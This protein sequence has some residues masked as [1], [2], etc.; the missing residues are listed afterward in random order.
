MNLE[1][2]KSQI[3]NDLDFYIKECEVCF[4]SNDLEGYKQKVSILH[5]LYELYKKI[6]AF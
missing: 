5:Y 2:I 1:Q 6:I 3:S 4:N